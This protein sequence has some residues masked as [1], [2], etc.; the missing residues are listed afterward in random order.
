VIRPD[1]DPHYR[2]LLDHA[3]GQPEQV[4]PRAI[5]LD[6]FIAGQQG[7]R[8]RFWGALPDAGLSVF[9]GDPRSFKTMAALQLGL[10]M[11]GG[12][13]MLGHSPERIGGVLYVGEEGSARALADRLARMQEA[14]GTA[15]N[16]DYF[17]LLHRQGVVLEDPRL[18]AAV[19][20]ALDDLPEPALVI[21]D[22]LA[23]LMQ[24]DEN[25]VRDMHAALRPVQRL[26]AVYDLP[27]VL[28]H[29]TS[30]WG[31][32]RSG[33]RLRGSSALWAASDAVVAF[34]R[35]TDGDLPLNS[36][37][38]VIEP[39]D[40]DA[41]LTAFTWDRDTFLM[42]A[43]P[44]ASADAASIT[45]VAQRLY[46]QGVERITAERLREHFPNAGHTWFMERLK[47]AVD[48]GYVMRLGSGPATHYRAAD[49]ARTIG[50]DGIV[51]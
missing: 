42:S 13:S 8:R 31:E 51:Q 21:L 23:A 47:I 12:W 46:E 11:A 20:A 4:L 45:L 14:S 19:P 24:G 32:G 48:Q 37:Q 40:G 33:K 44:S 49:D 38:I 3:K 17:R 36:G 25:S 6:E 29:H 10:S 41:V 9:S 22:S 28:I 26:I 7:E 2:D 35:D 30:K 43:E 5:P 39:K 16:A 27:V 1:L 15:P 50:S 34:K 18:W